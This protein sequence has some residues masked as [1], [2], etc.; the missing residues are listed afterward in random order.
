MLVS[1]VI[2]AL[3]EE[4]TIKN[5]LK[6]FTEQ[7]YPHKDIE[8][9]LVDGE[10]TDR[11]KSIMEEFAMANRKVSVDGVNGANAKE[12]VDG[13][14]EYSNMGFRDVRVYDNPKKVLP[15][16]WNVAL[17]NYK[18]DAILKVDAHAEIPADFVTNNVRRLE[19]GEYVCGG[20]RPCIVD[21]VTP[22]K[23]TL[24]MAENSMFGASVAPYRKKGTSAK[25]GELLSLDPPNYVK[26]V[27]HGAYRREVFERVGGFNEDLVRTEDNEIHYR[28]REAGFKIAMDDNI[29]SY[30]HIRSSLTKMLKQKYSNGLWIGLTTGVCPDCLSIYHYVPF[31]FV[32]AIALSAIALSVEGVLTLAGVHIAGL[33]AKFFAAIGALTAAMWSMY[34][35][36]AIIM[37]IMAAVA[38][39]AKASLYC[40]LLPFLFLML[41]ISYGIGTIVGFLKLPRWKK[42]YMR[43]RKQ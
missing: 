21:D 17:K 31:L 39:K 41:H 10:S 3:N 37:S 34:G 40:I 29:V 43:K 12:D 1:L 2:I 25:V 18:G 22:W 32:S 11:T 36:L 24:L 30:Q 14:T 42:E 6:N 4:N 20:I 26:S 23:N 9:I 16:G 27:F 5:L 28:I 35:L 8:V 33:A 19:S 7:D 13:L 15:A 38:D